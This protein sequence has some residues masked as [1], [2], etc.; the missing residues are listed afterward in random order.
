VKK[1]FDELTEVLGGEYAPVNLNVPPPVPVLLV[2][3]NGAGKTTFASKIALH[4]RK[5]MKKNPVLVPCDIH[6][7]AAM[8][9][10]KVLGKSIDVAVYDSDLSETPKQIAEKAMDWA[11]KEG[12]DVVIVDTAGRF[13]V[14]D[15]L[16]NELEDLQKFL[17]PAETLF[18]ADA[19][20]GQEAVNVAKAF[21]ERIGVTGVVLTKM[22]GDARGGAAL[23][24]KALTGI[25][26][27][28]VGVGE[29]P[30]DL[31]IFH[32]DR[33][34]G[35]ILEM[36]DVLSLVER[37]SEIVDEEEALKLQKK[38]KKNEFTIE[39]FL[40]QL[41]QVKK[42]GSLESIM[43]M[44]PGMGGAMKNIKD[45]QPA[46]DEMKKIEAII[47]SMTRKEREN[48]KIL[49]SSR[50]KRIARGSGTSVQDINRF[51][52]MFMQAR[53]MMTKMA[54]FMPGKGGGMPKLPFNPF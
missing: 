47:S 36:G 19:M 4:L 41:K 8:D 17:N 25:P 46:E 48:Y 31:E 49:N 38:L 53:K 40:T 23:S 20:T 18:V 50:K 24:I 37:A 42:L 34:A 32:P 14:D 10:L 26:V 29:K 5:K 11:R 7:P 43:K 22:D 6:R 33:V 15:E 3:L 35:R 12:A 9:Q 27:K 21:Q 54:K 13:Q 45:F 39:D 28:W 51:I 44:I 1:L 52:K 16:M 2:G 30:T